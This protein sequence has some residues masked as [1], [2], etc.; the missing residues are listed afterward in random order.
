MSIKPFLESHAAYDILPVSM[1]MV[2]IDA[3]L[4]LKK[5][6]AAFLLNGTF[7]PVSFL[8]SNITGDLLMNLT[9]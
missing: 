2:V 5:A 1:K 7:G 6:V 3:H 8:A 9:P 4:P